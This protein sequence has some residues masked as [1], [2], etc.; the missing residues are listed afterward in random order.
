MHI[1]LDK[2]MSVANT[3]D[4]V[5]VKKALVILLDLYDIENPDFYCA[6]HIASG[7]IKHMGTLKILNVPE[8][9]TLY[10]TLRKLVLKIKKF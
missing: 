1:I 10:E 6:A 8:I 4:A 2:F 9:T 3:G 5:G 7:V